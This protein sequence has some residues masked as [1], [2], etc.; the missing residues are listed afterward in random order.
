MLN[1]YFY[2]WNTFWK[3]K[4]VEEVLE[5]KA[6]G[7]GKTNRLCKLFLAFLRLFA[8]INLLCK[9]TNTSRINFAKTH[10]F[11][12]LSF[13]EYQKF[14]KLC[15][16][17]VR[18]LSHSVEH[19]VR[20]MTIVWVENVVRWRTILSHS[21]ENIVSWNTFLSDCAENFVARITIL[22]HRAENFVRWIP[23]LSHSAQKFCGYLRV[24]PMFQLRGSR[25]LPVS[26]L[27]CGVLCWHHH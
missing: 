26:I 27:T 16:G 20:S 13:P 7:L 23:I 18:I 15:L 14:L 8:I 10:P 19:F 5:K 3:F 24:W 21:A 2:C 17:E 6:P 12:I 9:I 4:V 11:E 1:L 22:S 25:W